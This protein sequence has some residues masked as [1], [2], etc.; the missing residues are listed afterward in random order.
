[1]S[2]A[3]TF[4]DV[5]TQAGTNMTRANVMDIAANKLNETNNFLVLSGIVVK[6]TKTDHYPIRQEKLQKWQG[7]ATTGRYVPV[8]N[9]ISGR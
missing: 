6:T 7:D 3:F 1:M 9:I 8:G 2:C 4:V 5:I